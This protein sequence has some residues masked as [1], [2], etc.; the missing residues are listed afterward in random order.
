MHS[1]LSPILKFNKTSIPLYKYI[2]EC[3]RL[4]QTVNSKNTSPTNPNPL[5]RVCCFMNPD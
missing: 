2:Q 1:L 5:I 3:F 4:F